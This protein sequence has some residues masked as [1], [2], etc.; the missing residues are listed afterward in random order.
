MRGLCISLLGALLAGGSTTVSAD[1]PT[2]NRVQAFAKLPDWSGIWE[3]FNI[4]PSGSA[5]DKPTLES[6][7]QILDEQSHPPYN[8]QWRTKIDSTLAARRSDS[9]I[10]KRC[11][12]GV[13]MGFPM[14]VVWSPLM[15]QIM[16]TPEM[17][18]FVFNNRETR[19]ILTDGSS[20]PPA[21]ELFA[22]PWG[23][24]VG[25]WEGNT[26]VIDTTG[27]TSGFFGTDRQFNVVPVAFSEKAHFIEHVRMLDKNTLEDVI[28]I[29]DPVALTAPWILTRKYH[30]VTAVDRVV[31]M[32]CMGN[33]RN[34]IVDGKVTL[35]P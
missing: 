5:A 1:S 3:E 11:I 15:F 29:Y 13:P 33:D 2:K 9:E 20:H 8:A 12:E 19:R 35:T 26:L 7:L 21:D 4:G 18:A 32:D 28:T 24:S 27:T 23:D 10:V 17:T 34:P 6:M 25:H 31:E 14:L 30:R 22:N 16:V